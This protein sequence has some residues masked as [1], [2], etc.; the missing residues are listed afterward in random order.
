LTQTQGRAIRAALAGALFLGM[1]GAV[2]GLE[3]QGGS[4]TVLARRGPPPKNTAAPVTE[5]RVEWNYFG[6]AAGMAVGAVI[7]FLLGGLLE[8]GL[9]AGFGRRGGTAA[10]VLAGALGGVL[11][12]AAVGG[13]AGATTEIAVG[14]NFSR[15]ERDVDAPAL[16][17]GALGGAVIG[18][19][20]GWGIVGIPG[21]I[22]PGTGLG[23]RRVA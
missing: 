8:R 10:V 9:A 15:F 21:P 6:A 12:G 1:F 13:V 14:P 11:L 16:V 4:E 23:A 20:A 18:T 7:G 19:L 17:V 22:R 2:L 3:I 5:F